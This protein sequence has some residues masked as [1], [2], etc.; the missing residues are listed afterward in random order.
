MLTNLRPAVVL[1]F[2]FTVLTG[3]AY[4]LAVTGI[5]ALVLPGNAGGSLIRN[6]DVIVGSSL[7]GQDFSSDRY[8]RPRPSATAETAYNAGASS[9]TNLG[10]TSAKLRDMVAE[11]VKKQRDTGIAAALPAD[12]VTASGSGLDPHVSPAFAHLQVA[13][14][15]KARN[16]APAEVDALVAR[17]TEAPFLGVFGE[18]RVNVLALNMALDSLAPKG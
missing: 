10:P 13:R 9:G 7:I 12:A 14:V 6:G 3:L 18:P 11:A 5:A 17:Q 8:F 16:L 1:L 2:L 4:P 15:A